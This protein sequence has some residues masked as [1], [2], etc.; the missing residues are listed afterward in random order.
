MAIHK[1]LACEGSCNSASVLDIN[2]LAISISNESPYI[3]EIVDIIHSRTWPRRRSES[4]EY[5]FFDVL[6]NQR[7][8][9]IRGLTYTSQIITSTDC[10]IATQGS[11]RKR[12]AFIPRR[13]ASSQGLHL[14]LLSTPMHLLAVYPG[15][16]A[17]KT[18]LFF[19]FY[20]PSK[21]FHKLLRGASKRR[22]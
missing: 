21:I 8:L 14:S 17:G 11:R 16:V 7:Q 6:P 3:R 20:K 22:I 12:T 15:S 10:G 9:L 18:P 4:A 13:R 5:A 2:L 19:Y 1:I